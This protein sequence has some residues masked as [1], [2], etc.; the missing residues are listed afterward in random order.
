PVND[1]PSFVRGAD[2]TSNEDAGPQTVAN[3][4]TA[5]SAGPADE[6]GQTVTFTVTSDNPSL[7]SAG[8]AV[9]SSGTLTYTAAANA[10]GTA[11][12]TVTPVNDAPSFTPGGNVTV[13]EDSGAYSA[14]WA[15][16]ISAGPNEGSQTVNFTATNDNN[17]LFSSQP[18]VSASGVLTF[19][20]APNANGT[21]T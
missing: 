1:A 15:S 10:N 13:L 4:A 21:A 8:P 17:A 19:T 11:T 5:I 12:V 7:F 6:S 14:A 20:T 16:G 2:Q 3:W 9:S 18:A